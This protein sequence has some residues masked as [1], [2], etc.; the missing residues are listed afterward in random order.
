[1]KIYVNEKELVNKEVVLY[2]YY[3]LAYFILHDQRRFL[4][5]YI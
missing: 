3:C 4:A 5:E 1:M 2:Y